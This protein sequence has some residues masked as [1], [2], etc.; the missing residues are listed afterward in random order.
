M[1]ITALQ[2][3]INDIDMP[4]FQ[5][6][7]KKYKVK[8]KTLDTKVKKDLPI[9]R[10]TPNKETQQAIKQSIEEHKKGLLKKYTDVNQMM[11]DFLSEED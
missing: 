1:S 11:E 5:S 3:F 10:A 6:L 8:T 4:I 9:E 7:F 2:V